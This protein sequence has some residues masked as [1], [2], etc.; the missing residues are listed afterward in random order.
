M[1]ERIMKET[2][3]NNTPAL[4][5]KV[6]SPPVIVALGEMLK[7]NGDCVDGG[8]VGIDC[9]AGST[10]HQCVEGSGGNLY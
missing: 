3:K 1:K 6:Y 4:P 9:G 7:G 10:E 5:R 2:A 8:T